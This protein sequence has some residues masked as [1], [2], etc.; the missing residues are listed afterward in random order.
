M[1]RYFAVRD[2][3]HVTRCRRAIAVYVERVAQYARA[4][5]SRRA[6]DYD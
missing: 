1:S 3:R 2:A 4:V 6:L 5:A